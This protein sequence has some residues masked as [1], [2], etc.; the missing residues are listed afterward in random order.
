MI[1]VS[2]NII[3]FLIYLSLQINIFIFLS[4]MKYSLVIIK[5]HKNLEYFFFTEYKNE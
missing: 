2:N 1:T 4:M 3:L 5:N